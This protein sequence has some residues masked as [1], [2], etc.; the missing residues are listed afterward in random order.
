MEISKIQKICDYLIARA[1][2][3][4]NENCGQC[5]KRVREAVEFAISPKKIDHVIS[6]KDYGPSYEKAGF[7]KVFCYPGNNKKEYKPE[8][9]DIAIIN[10]DPHGHICVFV[11]GEQPKSGKKIKCWVSDFIQ[12]DMYGGKIR[13]KDPSF[14]IYRF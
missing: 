7:R 12:K 6:A 1:E 13:L 10:Y 5:A 4:Y 8:I 11:E 2:P 9:G 3:A 14:S